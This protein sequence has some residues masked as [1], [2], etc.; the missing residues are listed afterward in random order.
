MQSTSLLAQG[1]KGAAQPGP[2]VAAFGAWDKELLTHEGTLAGSI[3]DANHSEQN[4]EVVEGSQAHE[5][6]L[7]AW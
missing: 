2:Q 4:G 3:D 5:C 7:A 6:F 1:A